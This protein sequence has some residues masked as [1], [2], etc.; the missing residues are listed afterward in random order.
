MKTLAVMLFLFANLA[1]GVYFAYLSQVPSQD[2]LPIAQ[3]D[4][5]N[6]NI[7]KMSAS[8]G[9]GSFPTPLE[10]EFIANI[11]NGGSSGGGSGGGNG[12]SG[13]ASGGGG[14]SGEGGSLFGSSSSN[15]GSSSGGGESS[16][17]SSSSEGS[18]IVAPTP[19]PPAPPVEGPVLADEFVFVQTMCGNGIKEGSEQ[20][21]GPTTETCLS[22]G[23]ANGILSCTSNCQINSSLCGAPLPKCGNDL[24]ESGEVCDGSNVGTRSCQSLGYA[25]GSLKCSSNCLSFDT[26]S[27]SEQFPICGNGLIES[28]EQCDGLNIGGATCPSVLG[29]NYTGTLACRYN[30]ESYYTASCTLLPYFSLSVS[31]SGTGSGDVTGTG[32]VCGPDCGESYLY[33]AVVNLSAYPSSGSWFAGWGGFCSG[34]GSCLITM[35]G[36]KTAT[37]FFYAKCGNGIIDSGEQCD[38]TNL[39]G[40][41]C[42]SLGYAGGTLKCASNCMAY[43]STACTLPPEIINYTLSVSKI[44]NGT[45]TGTG[46]N[47]G[48]DCSESYLS[49]ANITLTTTA[50]S[51]SVFAGWSGDCSG[52]ACSLTMSSNKSVTANFN[53]ISAPV[54]GNGIIESG[55]V[56]DGTNLGGQT[57]LSLG[58][59]GGSLSCASSCSFNTAA[60][61]TTFDCSQA[62][63]LCV[64]DTAG[65]TQE[66]AAI[67]SAVNNANAGDTVLVYA[68]TYKE[69]VTTIRNG[70]ATNYITIRAAEPNVI[71]D[72]E[73]IRQYCFKTED[74]YIAI[75][76]FDCRNALSPLY[77]GAIDVHG[78]YNNIKNNTIRN[79]K[80]GI[81]LWGPNAVIENNIIEN[82]LIHNS[83]GIDGHN[84][85]NVTIIGNI[86]NDFTAMGISVSSNANNVTVEKNF[87]KSTY[88]GSFA[89]AAGI[90]LRYG[91]VGSAIVPSKNLKV[92]SNIIFIPNPNNDI[93]AAILAR[94]VEQVEIVGNTIYGRHIKAWDITNTTIKN[95]II[96]NSIW[97]IETGGG[98][99]GEN[100]VVDYNLFDCTET[101]ESDGTNDCIQNPAIN[102][103]QIGTHNLYKVNPKF[104]NIS[105]GDFNLLAGSTVIDAGDPTI[106]GTDF[107]GT[108][109][110]QGTSSDIGAIEYSAS[111]IPPLPTDNLA[112]FRYNGNPKGILPF[113]TNETILSL[114][115]NE[116]AECGYS[117][118]AGTSYASMTNQFSTAYGSIHSSTISGLVNGTTYIYYI[119][120]QDRN[121]NANTDDFNVTFSVEASQP[122]N[123]PP[124]TPT[125]LVAVA[126][127]SSQINLAWTASTDN[128]GVVGYK[129]YR[130]GIY[131]DDSIA[132][133]YSDNDLPYSTD[134]TYTVAAFDTAG[135]PSNQSL[136]STAATQAVVTGDCSLTNIH[137]V[138]SGKEHSTMQE[139][140]N[141]AQPN[142]TVL[143]FAGTY[144]E[145]VITARS[146]EA[147]NY[148]TIKAA[149]PG[150]IIDGENSRQ[151]CIKTDYGHTHIL[152]DGFDC[153]NTDPS[154]IGGAILIQGSN[155][156]VRNSKISNTKIGIGVYGGPHLIENNT[157][158]N[159][160]TSSSKSIDG[161]NLRKTLIRKNTLSG[162]TTMGISVSSNARGVTV[163]KNFLKTN[164]TIGFSEHVGI[165]LRYPNSYNLKVRENIISMPA[166]SNWLGIL[167]RSVDYAEII[168][169]TIYNKHISVWSSS[170]IIIKNNIAVNSLWGLQTS[171][172]GAGQ[173]IIVDYNL[174]DCT[175]TSEIDGVNDCIE[176]LTVGPFQ[177]GTHNLYKVDPMFA[178]ASQDNFTLLNN[179]PAIDSGDPTIIGTDFYGTEIPQGNASDIGAV[180]FIGVPN[181]GNGIIDSGEQCD[182]TNL[183]GATCS[184][185]LGSSYTGTLACSSC[186][187]NTTEC[188]AANNAPVLE[189]IG[190][191]I[192]NEN[193]T[194]IFTISATDVD[195]DTITYSAI[196]IPE[197][198]DFS[199][200]TFSWTPNLTQSGIYSI[201]FMASDSILNDSETV[202]IT[203][204]DVAINSVPVLEA[205]G[206]KTVDE[207]VLLNFTVNAT[208]AENDTLVYNASNLPDG[209]SFDNQTFSWTPN[210]T[211]SGIYENITFMVSDGL[212]SNNETITI[213]VNDVV[214]NT[215]PVMEAIGNKTV[216]EG[217]L[218]NFT[219]NATDAENDTL[220]YNASNLPDG[221]SFDNQTF[222]WTP[223]ATQ[224]GIYENITFMVSDGLLTATE[225]IAII[226]ND[227]L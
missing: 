67:Q 91:I 153:R 163:E 18:F 19:P 30:C 113:G 175:A 142:E 51:G 49:G 132:T 3:N 61:T 37:A 6:F 68:G 180:E 196:N 20:C 129:I 172:A 193:E 184:S 210:A 169:N 35:N 14:S 121:S 203:V 188:I 214:V 79:A 176:N 108:A 170:N 190:N 71:I 136:P 2:L 134:F 220:V 177:I 221:A 112:S 88:T 160:L 103:Y 119:K 140:V 144:N 139:A 21:D 42:S 116:N 174:F 82:N 152:I 62:N 222:S 195:N 227:I 29:S 207:G 149:E 28:G 156:V 95:N 5:N 150:V 4:V 85:R 224:S 96:S 123:I 179:S 118:N 23:Y 38:G 76:G 111:F 26:S 56:C 145:Q 13:S 32:I 202:T 154:G 9:S 178:N 15:G 217:S 12:G 107:Y 151:Y 182:G 187:Y 137:C 47:C 141:M 205:I 201:T 77:T 57:C 209:A 41:S 43:N 98:G 22:L 97:G 106:T 104:A 204:N 181:C 194:I 10:T 7:V 127:S 147:E 72:E 65:P 161:H 155:N 59:T 53:I 148:I 92:K 186:S 166:D 167:A 99:A 219:V 24:I 17:V 218:L 40:A 223:N 197:G 110:P 102:P 198:S 213:T 1:V 45:V 216:D 52:T 90:E 138:G 173:K 27:C 128:V 69:Q 101:A 34:T 225:I 146:G 226:V 100:A 16:G 84:L 105:E 50:S 122:E 189:T 60:C 135:N 75:K 87:L 168:G 133:I 39:G 64:D 31:K 80:T 36:N 185:V 73:K 192:V 74:N 93:K 199:N 165:E 130:N 183:G 81:G 117:T 208:D 157:V 8:S 124:S 109:I 55:E 125:N 212:L 200:Q 63:I 83:F 126:V 86:V 33:G 158:E 54:C 162:F 94:G 120:C 46:I 66:Y 44:G 206:N 48:N 25:A 211:Q 89:E 131:V 115:T 143:V 58:Y 171:S 11:S 159:N 70:N 191:K 114:N 78:S 164:I 215:A